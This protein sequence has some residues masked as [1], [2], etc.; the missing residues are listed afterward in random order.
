MSHEKLRP[1]FLFDEEKIKQLKQI[2]PECFGDG[3][4]NFETLKQ[5]LGEWTQDED[6]ETEHFGLFWPGKKDAR[7]MAAIPPEG[8]LVPV[9]GEGLKA[10]GT[11]D[12][13]GEN[14]SKNIFIE[15]ENLEVLKILQK[16]YAGKIKMI[17]I[18]P[19]YNTGND[20]IYDDDFTEPLQE[21][22][23]RT[24]QV[25]EEGKALTTNKRAD[26]RFHSKWLSM[27]YPRL[28]LARNL[29]HDDGVLFVSIDENE[30][31]NLKT[32]LIEVFGDE[33]FITSIIWQKVYAPKNT[34]RHFSEDHD[35]IVVIAK[36]AES[37]MPGLL[38]RT[39]EQDALYKNPDNDPRGPWMSDNLTARNYYGDGQ[40]EI[41]GPTGN[42]F[43][44][45]KGRYWR[46]SY[47]NFKKLD[48]DNRVWWG[49]EG[50]NMPRMKRFLSEVSDG[51]VPQTLW[52]YKDVGH[53]QEAKKE[54]LKY[55]TFENTENVLNSVKPT[56]LIDRLIQIGSKNESDIILDFFGGSC[57]TAQSVL[58]RNIIENSNRKF[59]V[60][61]FPEKLPIEEKEV[62][63]ISDLGQSRIRKY[64]SENLNADADVGFK[65][66]K[67]SSSNYKKWS[68]YSGP[69]VTALEENL[70]LFNQEPLRKG[71]TKEALLTE[72]IL[73]EGFVLSST[74]K[75]QEQY[76]KNEVKK[77]SDEYC[78]HTLLVCLDKKIAPETIESLELSGNDIFICLDN[79]IS[80]VDKLR[81]SDKGLIKTI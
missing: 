36:N 59:I 63:T 73:I 67:L 69:S 18:D 62:K 23:R 26:G 52:T 51:R 11:P 27:M 41:T 43:T 33:N 79:A 20:F 6:G 47:E 64:S 37:W 22:L 31:H 30:I 54:L 77:V 71:W 28:R 35:Y 4:I 48:E 81:L 13:D 53:T 21:Y 40:Y 78:Q 10:D 55:V 80:N 8:T 45:G 76:T 56:R 58:K 65:K 9:Y 42:T 60:V 19:P 75:K 3:K 14:D 1:Q 39:V 2:A 34:A 66:L 50:N 74:I 17:Y 68:N 29:L 5:N 46:Q 61:Q 25:D 44:P 49:K 12:S 15:G 57:P 16:S 7:R 38:P 24:G 72:I 32:L 70:D